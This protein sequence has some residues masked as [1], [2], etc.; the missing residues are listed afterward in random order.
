MATAAGGRGTGDSGR[1]GSAAAAHR[2][3]RPNGRGGF[4]IVEARIAERVAE[5]RAANAE[6][7][8]AWPAIDFEELV[9]DG[10]PRD[11]DERVRRRGCLVVRGHFERSH[12]LDWDRALVEYLEV[13]GFAE[14]YRGPGDQFFATVDST[15]E[16]FPIYWSPAQM[17]ARQSGAWQPS[18]AC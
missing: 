15:P 8:T 16:I 10:V 14:A 9:A 3:L 1:E 12:A 2:C 4:E 6:F 11:L 18:S 7:G 17:Q 5:V 13:N